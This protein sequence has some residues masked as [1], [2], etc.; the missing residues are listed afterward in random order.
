MGSSPR[1]R[2][3]S[4]QLPL[5]KHHAGII[6]AN[7]GRISPS[8]THWPGTTDHPREYGENISSR[9]MSLSGAGSSPRIRG[10]F[11]RKAS[12]RAKTRI[13]PANTGRIPISYDSCTVDTDHPREYG[14]NWWSPIRASRTR[15]SSPRIRGESTPWTT[16]F[17]PTRIIPANTGRIR[18]LKP[19]M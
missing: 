11:C 4:N 5:M 2:G 8:F 14:E 18:S 6:P 15:G 19:T 7:T 10:E 17:P 16:G 3:E 12:S 9:K 13:I 1:I